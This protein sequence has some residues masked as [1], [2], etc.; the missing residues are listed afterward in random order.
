MT[1]TQTDRIGKKDTKLGKRLREQAHDK[2]QEFDKKYGE[3]ARGEKRQGD[4]V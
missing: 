1:Q 3:F 4:G 2:A